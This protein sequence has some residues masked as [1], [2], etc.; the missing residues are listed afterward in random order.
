M[1]RPVYRIA[2]KV[3]ALLHERGE[4]VASLAAKAG[5]GRAHASQVLANKPG[6]GHHTR[7]RLTAFLTAEELALLGW[8]L[9]GA[10]LHPFPVERSESP[11]ARQQTAPTQ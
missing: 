10:P 2:P 8:S 5:T 11:A 1:S 3:L 4:T 6:R 9:G 7:R